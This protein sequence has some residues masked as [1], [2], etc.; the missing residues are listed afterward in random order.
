M[1]GYAHLVAQG[2]LSN[3]LTV[4]SK[5]SLGEIGSHLNNTVNELHAKIL[6]IDGANKHI[7]SASEQV[8]NS[9]NMSMKDVEQQQDQTALVAAATEEMAL[10]V[11]EVA[12]NAETAS[13][14]TQQAKEA[15]HKGRDFVFDTIS[16]I[17][18]LAGEVNNASETINNLQSEVLKISSVLEVIT[19]IADQTNLL[20]LNAAI[21]AARAGEH[22]RGFAVVAEEVR[23]LAQKTQSSTEEINTMISTLQSGAQSSVD[24]MENSQQGAQEAVDMIR[25]AGDMLDNIQESIDQITE[26]NHQV[27]TATEEQS[28]VAK[29]IS[30]N[31]ENLKMATEQITGCIQMIVEANQGL[32][33]DANE[34]NSLVGEFKLK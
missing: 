14:A 11:G 10:T 6:R 2:D 24:V 12:S 33:N 1:S 20:A 22:G 18:S 5:D 25:Q 13:H 27:A 9:V 26:Q 21:E 30:Q 15:A 7:Q 8:E 4:Q 23:S 29:E 32:V 28:M 17:D 3:E 31:T 34:L 16:K 19:N